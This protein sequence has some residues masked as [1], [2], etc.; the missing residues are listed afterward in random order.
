MSV[1]QQHFVQDTLDLK[2]NWLLP[3]HLPD[4]YTLRILD[5]HKASKQFEF[6]VAGNV[7]SYYVSNIRILGSNFMIH[8][9]ANSQGGKNTT[10]VFLNKIPLKKGRL[11]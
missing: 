8:L 11:S 6:H 3:T 10:E 4:N 9:V 5:L 2:V 7:N 1:E